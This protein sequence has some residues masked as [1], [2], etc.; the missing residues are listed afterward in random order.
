MIRISKNLPM[1]NKSGRPA[2]AR[3][4]WHSMEIG[5]SFLVQTLADAQSASR[6]ARVFAVYHG[7]TFKTSMR[8]VRGGIRIWRIA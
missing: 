1:P 2:N 3:Y 5:D 7:I 8:T 4:P 6:A